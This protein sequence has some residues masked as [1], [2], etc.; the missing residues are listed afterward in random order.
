MIWSLHTRT[1]LLEGGIRFSFRFNV[2]VDRAGVDVPDVAADDAA[3]GVA[4]TDR[5]GALNAFGNGG[6]SFFCL[7]I[8]AV[9]G[10]KLIF[11]V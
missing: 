10:T 1:F 5:L 2:S 11:L 8:S 3:D 7:P 4:A 9:I 6:R